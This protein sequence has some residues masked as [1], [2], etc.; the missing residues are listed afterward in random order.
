M[1]VAIIG[2]GYI[3]RFHA[4]AVRAAGDRVTRIV[5]RT[6]ASAQTLAEELKPLHG[7]VAAGEDLREIL[8]DDALDAVILAQPNAFHEPHGT[9]CLQAGKHIL[10]EKPLAP[11]REEAQ[12]LVDRAAS[13]GR[14]LLTGHMWRWDPET[15]WL[16]EQIARGALGRVVRT[17]GY[18]IHEKWGPAG[19]FTDP[20]LAGGGALVDMGVHA[21]DTARY[22]LGDPLPLS[23]YARVRTS[24]GDYA[25]DDDA[26]LVIEW[27]SGACSVIQSG[28]WQPKAPG[29]EAATR[30]W[31]TGGYGSLFPTG[32]EPAGVDLAGVPRPDHA[33]KIAPEGLPAKAEHC[34]QLIYDAQY[35]EFARRVAGADRVAEVRP[36]AG[37]GPAAR[38]P[39]KG[40]GFLDEADREPGLVAVTIVEAAYEASRSGAVV[41]LRH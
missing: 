6:T 24:F 17:E 8:R 15:Q 9:A 20:A 35:R 11:T 12:R 39:S 28:W 3:A 38:S 23:V 26:H 13:A 21:I 25:V 7:P 5:S 27:D 10:V 19:W 41:D 31:G 4:R 37:A 22:L 14:V 18:G 29:P 32:V 34:D 40:G 33:G 16:R 30:L 1:N 36:A 2:S